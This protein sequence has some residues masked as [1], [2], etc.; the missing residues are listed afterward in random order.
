MLK[1]TSGN[2]KNNLFFKSWE[3]EQFCIMYIFDAHSKKRSVFCFPSFTNMNNKPAAP[4]T[5]RLLT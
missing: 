1:I 2:H 4:H 5:P 3:S